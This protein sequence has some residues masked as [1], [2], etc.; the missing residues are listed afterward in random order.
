ML[1]AVDPPRP[2]LCTGLSALHGV[3]PRSSF[4]FFPLFFSFLLFLSLSYSFLL[5]LSLPFSVSLSLC[6]TS[7]LSSFFFFACFFLSVLLS[8]SLSFFPSH[9]L[10]FSCSFS[11]YS[12]SISRSLSLSLLL[13]PSLSLWHFFISL[14]LSLSFSPQETKFEP[15]EAAGPKVRPFFFF[16]P[17]PGPFGGNGLHKRLCRLGS[18]SNRLRGHELG[19][20]ICNGI[21]NAEAQKETAETCRP[22]TYEL[23]SKR[24]WKGMET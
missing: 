12:L 2:L 16:R 4:S 11:F 23:I 19:I 8:L 18:A 13:T 10:Y 1:I 22:G 9:S 7:C 17:V 5:I 21:C 15:K 14:S 6:L 20:V 24:L 3:G